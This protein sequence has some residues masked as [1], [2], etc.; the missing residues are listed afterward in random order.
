MTSGAK[1]LIHKQ[2]GGAEVVHRSRSGTRQEWME[3]DDEDTSAFFTMDYS[4][5][6]RRRPI[7]N[8]SLKPKG[9]N[10]AAA[11]AAP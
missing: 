8:K 3:G 5:V 6:R 7:H 11:A 9:V 1:P 2:E 4:K 10:V